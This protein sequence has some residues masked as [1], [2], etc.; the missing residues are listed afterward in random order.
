ML[1]TDV[2]IE[3]PAW[4][5][6]EDLEGL[7]K[8]AATAALQAAD[9]QQAPP[10]KGPVEIA[11]NLSDDA[12]IQVL[13]KQFRDK[14][15]PTNVLS[16]PFEEEFPELAAGPTLLGDL[17]LS[18]ETI[19]REAIEQDKRLDHHITHLI[20][21]GVLHLCGY[22]HID[23]D[24]ADRMEHLEISILEKLRIPSPYRQS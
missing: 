1:K 23:E 20:V 15:K 12:H 18:Q 8:R 24:D 16:F 9:K 7:I 17:M 5:Q 22:D 11:I 13:N 10:P 4:R 19:W 14:D 21:H 3:A 6:V 2:L